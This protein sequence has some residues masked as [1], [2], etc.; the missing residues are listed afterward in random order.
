MMSW[1]SSCSV[2]QSH[3]QVGIIS[4]HSVRQHACEL[5]AARLQAGIGDVQGHRVVVLRSVSFLFV[6]HLSVKVTVDCV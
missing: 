5:A 1:L 2:E 4:H 3:W 6:L